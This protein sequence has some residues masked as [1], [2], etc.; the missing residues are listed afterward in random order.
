MLTAI[1]ATGTLMLRRGDWFITVVGDTP[2][3]T[4]RLFADALQ[5]TR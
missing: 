1:G 3:P 4:L 5:R 2:A